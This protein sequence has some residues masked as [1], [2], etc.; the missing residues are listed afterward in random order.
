MSKCYLSLC[1]VKLWNGVKMFKVGDTVKVI[2]KI[3]KWPS[4]SWNSRFMDN[5]IGH[6]YKINYVRSRGAGINVDYRLNTAID[7]K[8]VDNYNF[9]YPEE[10]L[11][12]IAGKQ[13]LF[14]FMYK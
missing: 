6:I 4:C 12:L 14:S 2:C 7:G 13:L 10:V 3:K 11:E 1:I 9:W 5:T 8:K